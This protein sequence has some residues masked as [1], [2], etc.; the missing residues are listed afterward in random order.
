MRGTKAKLAVLLAAGAGLGLVSMA[1][2]QEKGAK[3]VVAVRQATM[4]ANAKHVGAIKFIL[5]EEPTLIK[6]V[7]FHARA[8]AGA[9]EHAPE[10]FPQGSTQAP[11]DALPAI[12]EKPDQFRQ[13]AERAHGWRRS[14]PRPPRAGTCRRRRPRSGRWARR[15]AAAATRPSARRR[16]EAGARSEVRWKTGSINL[17]QGLAVTGSFLP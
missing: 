13:A 17:D 2:A 11:T 3:G 6:H 12:W 1:A 16:A 10:M 5:T 7:A 8:I 14:W 15:A 9:V 4:E